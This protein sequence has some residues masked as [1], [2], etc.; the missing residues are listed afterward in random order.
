MG[1]GNAWRGDDAVGIQVAREL[2]L[3]PLPA[4]ATIHES[5]GAGTGLMDLLDGAD[6]VIL[7]DAVRSGAPPGTL[8]RLDPRR[9]RLQLR[10]TGGSTHAFGVADAL[11]MA[12]SLG[13]LPARVTLIG[14]EVAQLDHGEQLSPAV[15]AAVPLAV[16]AVL[17]ELGSESHERNLP[18]MHELSLLNSL[19]RQVLEIARANGAKRVLTIRVKLGALSHMSPQ[20]FRVNFASVSR[21]T[22]AEGAELEIEQL[23]DEQDP[24]AQDILLDS[25]DIDD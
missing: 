19:M 11:E 14:V 10:T 3:Q 6:H 13:R 17:A 16:E 18:D 9:D 24:D 5:S 2:H 8:H 25:V 23:T 15:A 21:G 1:V 20:S 12:A 7:I 4:G 22:A